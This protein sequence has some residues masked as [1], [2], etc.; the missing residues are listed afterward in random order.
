[1]SSG[2]T[3]C[4]GVLSS[5]LNDRQGMLGGDDITEVVACSAQN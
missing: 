2:R 1:M 5:I 4:P 3:A